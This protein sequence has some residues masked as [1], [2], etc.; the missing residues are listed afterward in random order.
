MLMQ[1][2]CHKDLLHLQKIVSQPSS[3][4]RE[5]HT[6]IANL[7]IQKWFLVSR[8]ACV[9]SWISGKE[10]STKKLYFHKKKD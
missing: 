7:N 5:P 3:V 2:I 1:K 4:N 9:S 6:E 10:T 8:N